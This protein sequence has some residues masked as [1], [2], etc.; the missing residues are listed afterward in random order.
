MEIKPFLVLILAI[1]MIGLGSALEESEEQLN[2]RVLTPDEV[3]AVFGNVTWDYQIPE[4]L[5]QIPTERI[6]VSEKENKKSL[7]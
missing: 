7:T 4:E 2:E 6:I 1:S 3:M 5:Q